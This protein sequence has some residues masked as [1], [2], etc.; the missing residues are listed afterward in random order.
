MF[1]PN[2]EKPVVNLYFRHRG[3]RA[4]RK[5]FTQNV[6]LTIIHL[7]IPGTVK[8]F[9]Y[10]YLSASND[11]KD[12]TYYKIVGPSLRLIIIKRTQV[13]SNVIVLS[14]RRDTLSK[15]RAIDF[16]L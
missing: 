7:F 13:I 8:L 3:K 1:I 4:R 16:K 11:R 14:H 6:N 2:T 10:S 15:N 9:I 5:E 12:W